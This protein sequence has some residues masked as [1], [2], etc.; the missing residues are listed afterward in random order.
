M[1]PV[2]SCFFAVTHS[3]RST[4]YDPSG[5]RLAGRRRRARRAGQGLALVAALAQHR[6]L[7]KV[8]IPVRH[9]LQH[10][11]TLS[12][13]GDA[14]FALADKVVIRPQAGLLVEP[15]IEFVESLSRQARRRHRVQRVEAGIVGG[16]Q[17]AVPLAV[18]L[19][20]DICALPLH[21]DPPPEGAV[22]GAFNLKIQRL[23]EDKP[24]PT[25]D[26]IEEAMKRGADFLAAR[27]DPSTHLLSNFKADGSLDIT[28]AQLEQ[29]RSYVEAGGLLFTHADHASETFNTY[30]HKILVPKLELNRGG[31]HALSTSRGRIDD[32]AFGEGHVIFTGL[33]LT[34]GLLGTCQR[35]NVGFKPETSE[36]FLRNLVLWSARRV[37]AP[38]PAQ[39]P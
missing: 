23:A 34:T 17:L 36:A 3:P 18:W 16:Q 25:Y 30:V 37:P 29:I 9:G 21:S 7:F 22:P 20:L 39:K 24:E 28:D 15:R 6:I 27:F 26:Q 19:L 38:G 1:A 4:P 5:A 2:A 8:E 31:L 10:G 33:D 11:L 35:D 12:A 13:I 14:E 32:I